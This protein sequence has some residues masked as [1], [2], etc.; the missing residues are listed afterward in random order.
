MYPSCA[1][2]AYEP[3]IMPSITACG[4]P[5]MMEASMN[6]PGSPSSPLQMR[7]LTGPGEAAANFH[8]M[9]VGKPAPPR[10]RRPLAKHLFDHPLRRLL[11]EDGAR[12]V[13]AA[14]RQ[15]LLYALRVD[16]AHVPERHPR[17]LLVEGDVVPAAHPLAAGRVDVQQV[18]DHRA[19]HEV[20]ADH[21]RHVLRLEPRVVRLFAG[22]DGQRPLRTEAVAADDAELHLVLEAGSRQLSLEGVEDLEGSGEHAGRA[23][24][25]VDT[26][27]AVH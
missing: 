20:L 16:G 13:V 7:Y 9:P 6:A 24:A 26:T 19:A 1:P 14:A 25:D 2:M 12:G 27:P 18:V 21:A 23:G 17:L 8:F 11:G 4:S 10:P 5:S 3:M 22:D 15:I